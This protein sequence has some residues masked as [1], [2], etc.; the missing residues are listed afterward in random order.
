MTIRKEMREVYITSD[1]TEYEALDDAERHEQA[2]VLA[3]DLDTSG[4]LPTYLDPM[5]LA[6]W[7]LDNYT[8]TRKEP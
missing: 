7:M 1:G 3:R 5:S 6:L 8:M 4:E 2:A